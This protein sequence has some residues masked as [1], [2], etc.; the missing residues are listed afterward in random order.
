MQPLQRLLLISF[1][2]VF[3]NSVL[4]CVPAN[5]IKYIV[6]QHRLE[7]FNSD[8]DISEPVQIAK[9][10]PLESFLNRTEISSYRIVHRQDNET[11]EIPE[12]T[13]KPE[14]VSDA[15]TTPQSLTSPNPPNKTATTFLTTTYKPGTIDDP[16]W[17][18]GEFL[19]PDGNPKVI[20]P[21][22]V[23]TVLQDFLSEVENRHNE[24]LWTAANFLISVATNI[25]V[26]VGLATIFFMVL[27]F[28]NMA[29]EM[30]ATMPKRKKSLMPA[31]TRKDGSKA[32]NHSSKKDKKKKKKKKKSNMDGRNQPSDQKREGEINGSNLKT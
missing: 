19:D 22:P 31:S 30:N 4:A 20:S 26:I 8:T 27:P 5:T 1:T 32:A 23:T 7:N 24:I 28:Y 17:I 16:N 21:P 10:D 13:N 15:T 11:D 14:E 25:L 9:D 2:L 12:T 18:P 6:V 3:W 29:K